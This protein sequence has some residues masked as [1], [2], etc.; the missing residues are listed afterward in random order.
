MRAGWIGSAS[1]ARRAASRSVAL[2]TEPRRSSTHAD[3]SGR[4]T[5]W[6][7]P[8]RSPSK[9]AVRS[10]LTD[11]ARSA[12]PET[13]PGESATCTTWAGV[14]AAPSGPVD[15]PKTPYPSRK[16]SGVPTT[17]T[18]SL[19]PRA[20]PRALVTSSRWPPG[21]TPRPMPLVI[22][23]MPTASTKRSAASS[24]P[25]AHTSVPSTSTGRT[26]PAS[27]S[28]ISVIASGSGSAPRAAGTAGTAPEAEL[29]NSSIGTSTNTGPRCEE[30]AVVKAWCIPSRTSP[31]VWRVRASLETDVRI[32]GWS[33]SWRLPLPQRLA[34]ARPPTTT[35]GEPANCACAMALTPL[36]TPGPA[37]STASPGTRV[38]LPVAS[39]AKAAVCSWRTSSSRIGGSA[40]TAPSYIGKTCAPERVNIVST[41]CARATATASSPACPLS[42]PGSGDPSSGKSVL[43]L[44]RVAASLMPRRLLGRSREVV[45][46]G[47]LQGVHEHQQQVGP[48]LR[49]LGA[50]GQLE[51]QR[52]QE[53]LGVAA[54]QER[55]AVVVGALGPG[56]GREA[57][58][59]GLEDP[60]RHEVAAQHLHG[61]QRQ[62]VRL[63][64]REQ[65]VDGQQH[66][67]GDHVEHHGELG[68]GH[69]GGGGQRAQRVRAVRDG[70][71]PALAGD[72]AAQ[73]ALA[74]QPGRDPVAPL[75]DLAAGQQRPA[76]V[77]G[78]ALGQ[79]QHREA[80]PEDRVRL[81]VTD[82]DPESRGHAVAEAG[83]QVVVH[84]PVDPGRQRG[85]RR[86]VAE[87]GIGRAQ[88]PG[89]LGREV[90][91][92]PV[93]RDREPLSVDLAP[94]RPRH[95]GHPA[96]AR[97]TTRPAAPR[98]IN[99]WPCRR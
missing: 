53:G 65:P 80:A 21:T 98:M 13:W 10:P 57:G 50:H 33:S 96:K 43:S 8:V 89:Q 28:A 37:V 62:P 84:A 19:P 99:L 35:I 4:R 25:S 86:P 83:Q 32:G 92:R 77:P 15:P 91:E 71:R 72:E 14:D 60:Q 51:V 74:Q 54:D 6:S 16:S 94:V 49:R 73:V 5:T 23:G 68:G 88:H 34:G 1:A 66:A 52:P 47:R 58:D 59:P 11:A 45:G 69:V 39:A 9:T 7:R 18:R 75:E 90:V 17:T 48:E 26:A 67:V 29:K 3:Q 87:G 85:V 36:V 24:A 97:T 64:G 40:F 42:S 20:R 79:D 46:V 2:A 63:P 12:W 44:V 38:S 31:A 56:G 76:V 41:P 22:V 81:R 27:S 61:G 95:G 78:D 30:R 55:V 70:V 82:T 93:R